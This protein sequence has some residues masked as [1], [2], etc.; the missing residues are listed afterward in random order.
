MINP[1]TFESN[2]DNQY[3]TWARDSASVTDAIT[4]ARTSSPIF[5]SSKDIR[6]LSVRQ[7][8]EV[9]Y[10]TDFRATITNNNGTGAVTVQLMRGYISGRYFEVINEPWEAWSLTFSQG[11]GYL[12]ISGSA[13][14]PSNSGMMNIEKYQL[15]DVTYGRDG[16]N[17]INRNPED[18]KPKEFLYGSSTR[19]DGYVGASYSGILVYWDKTKTTGEVPLYLTQQHTAEISKGEANIDPYLFKQYRVNKY[20]NYDEEL[21]LPII[22]F[23]FGDKRF[24]LLAIFA[25]ADKDVNLEMLKTEVTDYPDPVL[26]STSEKYHTE[27]V[28]GP[29]NP[30]V[31]KNEVLSGYFGINNTGMASTWNPSYDEFMSL[32]VNADLAR[33]IVVYNP[34][35]YTKTLPKDMDFGTSGISVTNNFD[36]GRDGGYSTYSLISEMSLN[37]SVGPVTLTAYD[38]GV[39]R[40]Y[41]GKTVDP[42]LS[43]LSVNV[44]SVTY[45]TQA[46]ANNG[47]PGP[48]IRLYAKNEYTTTLNKIAVVDVSA[49]LQITIPIY[50]VVGGVTSVIDT[51]RVSLSDNLRF[52]VDL[53]AIPSYKNDNGSVAIE[54]LYFAQTDTTFKARLTSAGLSESKFFNK[55]LRPH[56]MLWFLNSFSRL[57]RSTIEARIASHAKRLEQQDPGVFVK[58]A[59]GRRGVWQNRPPLQ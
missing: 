59:F 17:A 46:A 51:L 54:Q 10:I 57:H 15:A 14:I 29:I 19:A 12:N 13:W 55:W 42:L 50:S 1:L 26:L 38:T 4:A 58:V 37:R 36:N 34:Q 11:W 7:G 27:Y 30:D 21:S 52:V 49:S 41:Y 9:V 53:D 44:T 3:L 20:Y 5:Q 22:T 8:S 16:I 6:N 31:C 43:D 39:D 32:V 18:R 23:K 56:I 45:T 28:M 25:A 24:G 33:E 35:G 2:G 40:R 47:D 48:G